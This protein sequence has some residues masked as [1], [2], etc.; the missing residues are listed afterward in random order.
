MRAAVLIPTYDRAHMLA[1][2]LSSLARQTE[3]CEVYVYDDG[4]TDDTRDVVAAF[5]GVRYLRREHLGMTAAFNAGVAWVLEES[6]CPYIAWLGSDDAYHPMSVRARADL[7]D[8]ADVAFSG[9][10]FCTGGFPRYGKAHQI[11]ISRYSDAFS[12]F[13][14]KVHTGTAMFRRECW[15]PWH[16]EIV[17]GGADL[18]WVYE[19]WHA[20]LR[21]AYT[22]QVLYSVRRHPGRQIEQRRKMDQTAVK[23]E[24][25]KVYWPLVRRIG[26]AA[27]GV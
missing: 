24:L 20:G 8:D 26:G 12:T 17:T 5:P 1:D 25:E 9:L 13:Q 4:S 3:P 11:D 7:L 23:R 6:D 16:E 10:Q 15:I 14:G 18:L 21:F 19:C 22:P 27:C 2:A